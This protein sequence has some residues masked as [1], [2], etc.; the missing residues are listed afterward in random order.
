MNYHPRSSNP[1]LER[2]RDA[3]LL[4]ADQAHYRPQTPN[5]GFRNIQL[6]LDQ[7]HDPDRLAREAIKYAMRFDAEEDT[8]LFWIGCSN[9]STVRAFIWTIEAARQLAS[10]DDGDATAIKL[11]EMAVAEVKRSTRKQPR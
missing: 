10:G 5:D 11:L 6:T 2:L 4:M 3:Y 7:I 9:F 1:R 8:R